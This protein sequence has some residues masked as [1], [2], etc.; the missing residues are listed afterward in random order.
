MKLPVL[1]LEVITHNESSGEAMQTDPQH[2]DA[3]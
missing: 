2:L 1:H 3:C